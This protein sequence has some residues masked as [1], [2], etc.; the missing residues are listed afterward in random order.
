MAAVVPPTR[1]LDEAQLLLTL[2]LNEVRAERPEGATHRVE[3]ID[4]AYLDDA[5]AISEALLEADLVGAMELIESEL[6][7]DEEHDE[8]ESEDAHDGTDRRR[9]RARRRRNRSAAR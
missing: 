3:H 7:P 5:A 2:A 4:R 9:R 6:P 1:D 8:E